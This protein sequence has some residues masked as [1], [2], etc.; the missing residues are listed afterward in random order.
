MISK[1][2]KYLYSASYDQTIKIWNVKESK[3]SFTLAGHS[4][5]VNS[6]AISQDGKYLASG[7]SDQTIKI[8]NLEEKREEFTLTGH[9]NVVSSVAISH[10]GTYLI[11]GSYDKTIKIWNLEEKR[12]E[13]T[14]A[15]HT[16]SVNSVAISKDGKYLIS[17]SSDLTIKI[18]NLEEKREDFNI[19]PSLKSE[20]INNEFSTSLS[21]LKS[22]FKLFSSNKRKKFSLF[23][24]SSPIDFD[25]FLDNDLIITEC[26]KFALFYKQ[27]FLVGLIKFFQSEF[28]LKT[29]YTPQ[30]ILD[31]HL[32]KVFDFYNVFDA[33]KY[34]NFN[35]ISPRSSCI[36]FGQYRYTITHVLCYSGESKNL[37]TILND[38]FI[39]ITDILGKSPIFYAIKKKNQ[40]CV[41]ILL[42]FISS[43]FIEPLIETQRFK[44]SLHAIRNDFSLIIQNSSSQLPEFLKK[45][46]LTSAI[47]FAKIEIKDLP[48][49]NFHNFKNC[50]LTD[51]LIKKP[52][53]EELQEKDTKI[54]NPVRLQNTAFPIS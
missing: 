34:Q 4:S 44:A 33:V 23:C 10:E 21:Y 40:E 22:N 47:F 30:N 45:I 38:S 32:Q 6:I 14:L 2:G 49:F 37:K 11:S 50:I 7:S 42:E 8:W 12:E 15:G 16:D 54:E 53:N 3:E 51:F 1:D 26:N 18:W 43:L 29:F 28:L 20:T 31:S 27:K 36:V 41:D 9:S 46:L 5:C 24:N 17:G 39:L 35:Y 25:D 52:K 19:F 13:F 48:M